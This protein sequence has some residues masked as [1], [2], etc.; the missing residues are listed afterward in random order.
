VLQEGSIKNLLLKGA[1]PNKLVLGLPLNGRIFK[2][3]NTEGNIG[4]W[5]ESEGPG[6]QGPYVGEPGLWGYNEVSFCRPLPQNTVR[7]VCKFIQS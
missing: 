4:F 6:M 1:A 3:I 2:L 5:K 7:V